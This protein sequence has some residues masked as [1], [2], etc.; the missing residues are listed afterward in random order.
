MPI[1]VGPRGRGG[2]QEEG[3]YYQRYIVKMYGNKHKWE[4]TSQTEF[5]LMIHCVLTPLYQKPK[6]I[7]ATIYSFG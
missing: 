6:M 3:K 5:Q 1:G 2:G 4:K 7:P